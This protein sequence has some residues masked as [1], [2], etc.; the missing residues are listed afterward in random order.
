MIFAQPAILAA[1]AAFLPFWQVN[2]AG[3]CHIVSRL[4]R[5]VQPPKRGV[6]PSPHFGWY[7]PS[8]EGVFRPPHFGWDTPRWGESLVFPA[9]PPFRGSILPQ[10]LPPREPARLPR[11][12]DSQGRQTCKLGR[13]R[14]RCRE[15]RPAYPCPK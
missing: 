12:L 10:G 3:C 13:C 1:A 8:E 9:Y 14:C 15:A 2:L 7:N 5:L 6:V 11:R 4:H